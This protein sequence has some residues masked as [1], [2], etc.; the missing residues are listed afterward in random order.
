MYTQKSVRLKTV[1]AG[2]W[3]K[4][5]KK[6]WLKKENRLK[7]EEHLY[8]QQKEKT[9]HQNFKILCFIGHS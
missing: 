5:G 8:K 9:L 2:T 7:S 1:A 3:E 6:V 4:G